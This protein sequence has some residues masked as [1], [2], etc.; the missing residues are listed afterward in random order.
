MPLAPQTHCQTDVSSVPL[1]PDAG[2][3]AQSVAGWRPS[4]RRLHCITPNRTLRLRFRFV[5]ILTRT[6]MCCAHHMPL[7]RCVIKG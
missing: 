5:S 4:H 3:S 6:S 7:P 1:P 2:L